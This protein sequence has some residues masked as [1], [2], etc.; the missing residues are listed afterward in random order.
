M[1]G[2]EDRKDTFFRKFWEGLVGTAGDLLTNP[3]KEQVAAK[4]QFKGSLDGPRANIFY[5]VVD[6]LRNAFIQA[7]QP[8]LDQEVDISTVG[9]QE[10]EKKGFF[11][12]LFGAD[13][14][15]EEEDAGKKNDK[16]E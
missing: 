14:K 2:P 4:L 5:A 7:L 16:A 9:A 12:K 13:G 8:S 10:E 3:K 6:L 15:K 11:K 1:L